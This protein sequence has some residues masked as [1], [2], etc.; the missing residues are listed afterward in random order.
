M[1]AATTAKPKPEPNT[2]PPVVRADELYTFTEAARRLR[3]KKHSIR[4]AKRKGLRLARY[5]SRDYVLGSDLIAFFDRLA[6]EQERAGDGD[7]ATAAG[8]EGVET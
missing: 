8:R 7:Q 4:Q 5:G 2:S 1:S 3:W 6:R